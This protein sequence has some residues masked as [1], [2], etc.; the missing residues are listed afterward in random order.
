MNN[1]GQHIE[2]PKVKNELT[3]QLRKVNAF[4]SYADVLAEK[5]DTRYN[6]SKEDIREYILQKLKNALTIASRL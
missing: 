1:A 2:F 6:V 4:W 3:E 5:I